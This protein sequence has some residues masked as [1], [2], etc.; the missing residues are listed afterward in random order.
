[1]AFCILLTRAELLNITQTNQPGYTAGIQHLAQP[2]SFSGTFASS[3]RSIKK[4]EQ[5]GGR[6]LEAEHCDRSIACALY[7]AGRF[8][9]GRQK[10]KDKKWWYSPKKS[11]FPKT[12]HPACNGLFVRIVRMVCM[13]AELCKLQSLHSDIGT[14][15]KIFSAVPPISHKGLA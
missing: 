1:N 15:R 4:K 13:I 3:Q 12:N 8:C 2:T 6:E 5:G 7:L 11:L 10:K 9:C 14:T